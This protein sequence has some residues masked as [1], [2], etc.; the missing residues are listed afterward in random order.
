MAH[1]HLDLARSAAQTELAGHL[2]D[3]RHEFSL[4]AG[5]PPDV[6]AEAE[7]A[8]A[9][10]ADRLPETDRTDLPLLTIDPPGSTDLDQAVHIRRSTGGTEGAAGTAG[11]DDGFT[12]HYAIADVPAFIAPGGALDAET[13][14]RGQTVYLP[15]GR[16]PL[17]PEVISEDTGSLLPGVD[18]GA[19]LWTF[20][21]DAEGAVVST[22]LERA[23][24]RSREQLTYEQAQHR[25]DSGDGGDTGDTG[26]GETS[27]TLAL[28]REVGLL[29]AAQEIRRGG[30]S[31]RLPEQEVTATDRGYEVLSAPP[32][33][34]EDW[35]AQMS[36]MTGIAAA[37]IMLRGRIGILRTMPPADAD[38]EAT[39]RARTR[40]LGHPWPESQPYGEYLRELD[41]ADPRDLAIMHAA[42]SLFRGAGYTSFD[43]DTPEV[44]VQAAIAAPYAHTTAPLRRLVDRFVL[45]TCLALVQGRPVP[46][47]VRALLPVLP[48]AMRE[49]GLTASRASN[50]AL[51]LV[52]AASLSGL[53][54][55]EFPAVV[56]SA[57]SPEQAEKARA[58]GRLPWGEVQ[59]GQ[60]PV[61]ARYEGFAEA[62]SQIRVELVTADLASRTV[63]F[64]VAGQQPPPE[65]VD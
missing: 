16:V 35:N 27:A 32:M 64:R 65:P 17:H 39:F 53:E 15:D 63:L 14:R 61:L 4:P 43:G 21:L 45:V 13:L 30:A 12:V 1:L 50:A 58:E 49:S 29:R 59:V 25:I 44:T 24:V 42:T 9:A 54:G 55:R 22:D 36:L 52:E 2:A 5:F 28:L 47:G 23:R 62:G 46:E 11:S 37:D 56:I 31:L 41:T 8:A 38:S 6:L 20:H 51:E 18:R 60:P 33:D 19:Y 48:E 10:T 26:S 7:R 57:P 34:V 3:L 40:A